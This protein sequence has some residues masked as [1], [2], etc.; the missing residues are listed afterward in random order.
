MAASS[1]GAFTAA[2]A[3]PV[4]PQLLQLPAICTRSDRALSLK[5]RTGI[6]GRPVALQFGHVD[7]AIGDDTADAG[8]VR[9]ID[10]SGCDHGVLRRDYDVGGDSGIAKYVSDTKTARE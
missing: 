10:S 6:I 9:D 5:T 4:D 2:T 3:G 1:L 7:A 8:V